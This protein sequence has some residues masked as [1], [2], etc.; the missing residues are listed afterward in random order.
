MHCESHGL[1]IF[2]RKITEGEDRL[3]RIDSGPVYFRISAFLRCREQN[4]KEVNDQIRA[5]NCPVT[6][7]FINPE[8]INAPT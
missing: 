2:L 1:D 8:E 5:V 7:N 6:N 4:R 3:Q